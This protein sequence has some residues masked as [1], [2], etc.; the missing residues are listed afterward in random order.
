MAVVLFR[1]AGIGELSPLLANGAQV[2]H[3]FYVLDRVV[4]EPQSE[5]KANHTEWQG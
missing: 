2:L 4:E 3:C 5:A 1:A